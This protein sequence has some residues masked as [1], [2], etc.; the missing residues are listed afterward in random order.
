MLWPSPPDAI[1]TDIMFQQV[2]IILLGVETH[3]CTTIGYMPLVSSSTLQHTPRIFQDCPKRR[4]RAHCAIP[5]EAARASISNSWAYCWRV[6]GWEEWCHQQ[7]ADTEILSLWDNCKDLVCELQD[8]K[9]E[10]KCRLLSQ[11]SAVRTALI[12]CLQSLSLSHLIFHSG[13]ETGTEKPS[14]SA[15]HQEIVPAKDPVHIGEAHMH[16]SVAVGNEYF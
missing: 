3:T 5:R 2:S 1:T 8:R 4:Q 9:N 14:K 6:A 16:G 13:I 10:S 7:V 11:K 15:V 12:C